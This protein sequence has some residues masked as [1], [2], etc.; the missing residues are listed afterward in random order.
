MIYNVLS[1]FLSCLHVSVTNKQLRKVIKEQLYL[2]QGSILTITEILRELNIESKVYQLE[3][4]ELYLVECP[5][6]VHFDDNENRF[7]V[8]IELQDC[9][10]KYF[11]PVTNKYIKEDRSIFFKKWT[12]TVL[13]PYTDEQSGDPE[14]T[15]RLREERTQ[16]LINLGIYTGISICTILLLLQAIPQELPVWSVLFF[17]KMIALLVVSQIVKIELGES[18]T[19]ITTICKTNDCGKVLNSKASKLFAGLTM[20][21]VGIIYFGVGALLLIIAPFTEYFLFIVYLLFFVNLF[22]LPYTLFSVGY[23]RFVLKTWCPFCLTVMG[24]LWVEFILGFTVR[25]TEVFPLSQFLLLLFCFTGITTIVGWL[26]LKRLLIET[27]TSQSIKMYVN[28]VKKDVDLF[29]AFLSNQPTISEFVSSSEIMLG[30]R[31]ANNELIAVITPNCHSCAALYQSIQRYLKI[32]ADGLKVILRFKPGERDDGWDN[33]IIE[34]LLTF[35]MNNQKE[36]ALSVLEEWYN[37]EYR[38][39]NTWKR[40]CGIENSV[41]SS[42]AKQLRK[43]YH[44]WLLS[45]DIPEAPAMILNNKLV[46]RY[47]T[48]EDVKYFLKRI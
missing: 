45:V 16:K 29:N 18:N 32:H 21:D 38:D 33:Q 23:Q 44:N 2:Y 7:V 8:V 9:Q 12:G 34:Y 42:E 27:K 40:K 22:T 25:W 10:I 20:G 15:K 17:L 47:Y 39:I 31:D 36:K 48:F 43:D 4:N 1:N 26:V 24:L 3:E 14:Y 35:S 6:I 46:P 28:T 41:V 37:M 13:V 11:D 19:L 30:A 5:V